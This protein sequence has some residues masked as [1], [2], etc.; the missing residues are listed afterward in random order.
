MTKHFDISFVLKVKPILM[1][2][3]FET[4]KMTNTRM[5]LVM[6]HPWVITDA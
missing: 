4:T 2:G 5:G 6:T 1:L 3:G